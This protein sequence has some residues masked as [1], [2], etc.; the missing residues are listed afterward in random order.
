MVLFVG[1]RSF[2]APAEVDACS[3]P[4][5][6]EVEELRIYGSLRLSLAS[7]PRG[8]REPGSIAARLIAALPNLRR[9]AIA[10]DSLLDTGAHLRQTEPLPAAAS[11]L[12]P[13]AS[14]CSS[15]SPRASGTPRGN[16]LGHDFGSAASADPDGGLASDVDSGGV[17]ASLEVWLLRL[18]G[19][20]LQALM[21]QPL[22]REMS[23]G[24]P[25]GAIHY[26]PL[27]SA[28]AFAA[29]PDPESSPLWCALCGLKGLRELDLGCQMLPAWLFPAVRLPRPRLPPPRGCAATYS[30]PASWPAATA[31]A[32]AV[33]SGSGAR[34]SACVQSWVRMA[35]SGSA[36]SAGSGPGLYSS[37]DYDSDSNTDGGGASEDEAED[38]ASAAA[39][40]GGLAAVWPH[41]T[42]LAAGGIL[43]LAAP[44][45]DG[46]LHEDGYGAGPAPSGLALP[47]RGFRQLVLR[48]P[49]SVAAL[50]AVYR[51]SAAAEAVMAVAEAR[52]ATVEARG[53]LR[54]R[55]LWAAAAAEGFCL[56]TAASGYGPSHGHGC[57]AEAAHHSAGPFTAPGAW[58]YGEPQPVLTALGQGYEPDSPAVMAAAA[59]AGGSSSCP[60]SPAAVVKAAAHSGIHAPCSA[61]CSSCA[62]ALASTLGVLGQV[63]G[64]APGGGPTAAQ[65]NV[66]LLHT[67]HIAPWTH[68]GA[69][70]SGASPLTSASL[71]ESPESQPRRHHRRHQHE[72]QHHAQQPRPSRAQPQPQPEPHQQQQQ[73]QQQQRQQQLQ[74]RSRD[75]RAQAGAAPTAAAAD[76]AAA[77]LARWLRERTGAARRPSVAPHLPTHNEGEE[78]EQQRRRR[79]QHSFLTAA[80]GARRGGI[81]SS[82]APS[83]SDEDREERENEEAEEEDEEGDERSEHEPAAQRR[84]DL[85]ADAVALLVRNGG[86]CRALTIRMSESP[87]AAG[88][89]AG[90]AGAPPGGAAGGGGGSSCAGSFWRYG[91]RA[92]EGPHKPW[93]AALAPLDGAGLRTLTLCCFSF[94]PGDMATLA[95]A[96]PGLRDR[97][98]L[99]LEH[100]PLPPSAAS[101]LRGFAEVRCRGLPPPQPLLL[102]QRSQ[103]QLA[104]SRAA[105]ELQD[106]LQLLRM[107]RSSSGVGRNYGCDSDPLS[108]AVAAATS[109]LRGQENFHAPAA[110]AA[111]AADAE[112]DKHTWSRVRMA[113]WVEA[114]EAR[115]R[116]GQQAPAAPATA[117]TATPAAA[118]ALLAAADAGASRVVAGPGSS[119]AA[120]AAASAAAAAA[121]SQ[122]AR[123]MG[124]TAPPQASETPTSCYSTSSNSTS[125]H[126]GPAGGSGGTGGDWGR[127]LK[128]RGRWQ[129]DCGVSASAAPPLPLLGSGGVHPC[130]ATAAAAAALDAAARC[131][132]EQG[133]GGGGGGGDYGG[134]CLESA[135]VYAGGSCTLA[136][137]SSAEEQQAAAARYGDANAAAAEGRT[138]GSGPGTARAS[139]INSGGS[140]GGGG[141]A[142]RVRRPAGNLALAL[143]AS[144]SSQRRRD[145]R[146]GAPASPGS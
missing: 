88:V 20:R 85:M 2:S 99:V 56:V 136:C 141:S 48:E 112:D 87:A 42:R 19:P 23:T 97:G 120:G 103:P 134:T 78:G 36:R 121:A 68:D 44:S 124:V 3:S 131:G 105:Q 1:A 116:A 74:Q 27:A 70:V 10:T 90:A 32:G 123:A 119:A 14:A 12:S 53:G 4:A 33:G 114:A 95:A 25:G 125:S 138:T 34:P 54:P 79:Q 64:R 65:P 94:A 21:L 31:A 135:P 118:A 110:A 47:P 111:S 139:S 39:A 101:E 15:L 71:S 18:L 50:A 49:Q 11:L 86:R 43:G 96:L 98:C 17:G 117:A 80:R 13:S 38:E 83:S 76:A 91:C 130:A 72:H 62:A 75:L 35:L 127:P 109:R 7:A 30:T 29:S 55:Q 8:L 22:V 51:A 145:L 45:D 144:A 60:A 69:A 132:G 140:G 37:G 73:Q 113:P 81:D 126:T 82:T 57:V 129:S 59:A 24:A 61:S 84:H 66:L 122:A 5:C 41:L 77:A 26:L 115:A 137:V 52:A 9:L 133:D 128:P 6:A 67:S 40:C 104:L 102:S 93:L 142:A 58:L 106:Q 92:A 100:C 143:R 146:V 108:A 89:T 107:R 16:C 46:Q 63:M 28:D